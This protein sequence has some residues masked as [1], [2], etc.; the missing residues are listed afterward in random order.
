M[1]FGGSNG[2]QYYNDVHQYIFTSG[3]WVQP[4]IQGTPPSPRANHAAAVVGG[5]LYVFGGNDESGTI[6]GDAYTLDLGTWEWAVLPGGP[7]ARSGA[8]AV[9]IG[10]K[11]SLCT[12]G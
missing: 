4:T 2:S 10:P 1:V 5:K 7:P 3:S 8:C 6:L 12:F 11:V 9:A